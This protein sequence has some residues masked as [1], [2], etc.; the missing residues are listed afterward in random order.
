MRSAL[1]VVKEM[2]SADWLPCAVAQFHLCSFHEIICSAGSN[3]FYML[4]NKCIQGL[5][6]VSHGGCLL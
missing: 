4:R 2:L 1:F 5:G 3:P 6:C